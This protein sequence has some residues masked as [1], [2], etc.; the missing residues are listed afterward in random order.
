MKSFFLVICYLLPF[1]VHASEE[2]DEIFY[3]QPTG[4]AD[5]RDKYFYELLQLSLEKSIDKFGAY[6]LKYAEIELP[7]TRIPVEMSRGQFVNVLTS[8][9][10]TQL[11]SMVLPIKIPLVKG[12]QGLRLLLIKKS[13]QAQFAE[14]ENLNQLKN[15]ILGQGKG[16]LDTIVFNEAGLD[17]AT[18]TEYHVL[19]K[20]LAFD[21]FDAFPRGLNEI[22]R[23]LD[24]RK[25]VYPEFAVEQKLVVYYDLPVYFF[26]QLGN[27][28]LHDR[29]QYGLN[30][31]LEDG[32]FDQLF[33]DY[34]GEDIINAKLQ[35]R[36]LFYLP[37]KFVPV[38]DKQ[39]YKQFWL[40]F[41]LEK[42][43]TLDTP[44]D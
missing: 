34:Y 9:T 26:V 38:I 43:A 40:P 17:V 7:S 24:E 31:A 14:V 3:P 25:S 4:K 22:Y 21:R 18:S 5:V 42:T 13:K 19:F 20:M 15:F 10:S 29:I 35:N 27:E 23:E 11:E 1:F 32:S 6:S 30:N 8:P 28:R 16:W 36:T 44:L 39:Q 33:F 37:N 12:I 41:I 2:V